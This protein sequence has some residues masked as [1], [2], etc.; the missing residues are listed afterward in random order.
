MQTITKDGSS[1]YLYD[2]NE[3]IKIEVDVTLIGDPVTLIIADIN[4]EN[5]KVYQNVTPPEDWEGNKY[6]FDGA[7]WTISP[8]YVEPP[9]TVQPET[10]G[11]QTL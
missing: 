3:I 10:T 8:T 11:T 4:T 5:G 1:C 9:T 6:L 7:T 2:D